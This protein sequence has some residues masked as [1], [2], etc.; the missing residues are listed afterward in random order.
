MSENKELPLI[1]E[2]QQGKNKIV[3]VMQENYLKYY[4]IKVNISDLSRQYDIMVQ[5]I[6]DT[7]FECGNAMLEGLVGFEVKTQPEKEYR[8]P[9]QEMCNVPEHN[10]IKATPTKMFKDEIKEQ[11]C[12]YKVIKKKKDDD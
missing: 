10:I 6:K 8:L 5:S 9:N 4:G 11:E 7:V 1:V 3:R 2:R 12:R